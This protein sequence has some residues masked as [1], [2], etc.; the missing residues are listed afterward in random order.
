[1]MTKVLLLII[2]TIICR[3]FNEIGREGLIAQPGVIRFKHPSRTNINSMLSIQIYKQI[4]LQQ[5]IYNTHIWIWIKPNT[6]LGEPRPTDSHQKLNTKHLYKCD[7][8]IHQSYWLSLCHCLCQVPKLA[9]C[10]SSNCLCPLCLLPFFLNRKSTSRG[11][12]LLYISIPSLGEPP[13]ISSP[14]HPSL[15]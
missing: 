1:M 6:S 13:L 4:Q 2:M 8:W 11:K 3:D 10:F 12:L 14:F 9:L 5:H 15:P 7:I